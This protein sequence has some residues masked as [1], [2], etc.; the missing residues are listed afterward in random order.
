LVILILYPKLMAGPPGLPGV[1]GLIEPPKTP[2]P[3]LPIMKPLLTNV[4][5][6]PAVAPEIV[7]AGVAVSVEYR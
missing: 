6:S 2:S 7:K 4:M 3:P 5:A 1:D